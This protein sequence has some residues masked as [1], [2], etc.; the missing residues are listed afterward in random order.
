MFASRV[1]KP[2][3]C[4]PLQSAPPSVRAAP[5]PMGVTGDVAEQQADRIARDLRAGAGAVGVS[6]P[7]C[8]PSR[9]ECSI[10][11]PAASA[12]A[13]ASRS[14]GQPLDASTRNYFEPRLGHDLSQVRV[15]ADNAAGRSVREVGALAYTFG[16]D[17]FFGSGPFREADA[18]SRELLTHELV[19]FIQQ[20]DAPPI[21]QRQPDP[22]NSKGGTGKKDEPSPEKFPEFV[23][24]DQVII[25]ERS[26]GEDWQ[27]EMSGHTSVASVK[28]VLFPRIVPPPVQIDAQR[29]LVQIESFEVGVFKITGLRYDHLQ[30]MEPSIA[31]LF[32]ANGLVD[33]TKE[34]AELE[35]ARQAFRR[36][37]RQTSMTGLVGVADEGTINWKLSAIEVALKRVTKRNPDLMIA[38]Y[39]HYAKNILIDAELDNSGH[40]GETEFGD[41]KINPDVLLLQSRFP[42]DDNL[43]LLGATLIHEFAH[44]PQGKSDPIGSPREE[45]KA[46]GIEIFLSERANDN[47]RAKVISNRYSGNDVIDVKS[48][49]HKIFND[50]QYIMKKLYE[51]IDNKSGAEAA[52]ARRMS[53]EFISKNE[54]D[55]SKELKAF[56]VDLKL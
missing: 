22:K 52:Q 46:Y 21:L 8:Q 33:E 2:S 1:P 45:A 9:L 34:P 48:G 40:L 54:A 44:T 36:A 14:L 20:Q 55:Y 4:A 35:K 31:K 39:Q 12:F 6:D 10:V 24:A 5:V 43:A 47:K 11:G 13:E 50:T 15:H 30:W 51:I 37:F 28:K 18:E 17:I 29:N 42:T 23:P 38:F 41:T 16:R 27:L 25:L 32:I 3:Q 7:I 53:V 56:I 26:T 49:S 19:H